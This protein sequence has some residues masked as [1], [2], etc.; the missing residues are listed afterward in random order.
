MC[1]YGIKH[2]C[3]CISVCV[4]CIAVGICLLVCVSV[5]VGVCVC[6]CVCVRSIHQLSPA[7]LSRLEADRRGGQYHS[8]IMQREREV[9]TQVGDRVSTPSESTPAFPLLTRERS[10]WKTEAKK[11]LD[12][13]DSVGL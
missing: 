11:N 5:C 9:Q 13:C 12:I 2:V 3:A 10:F 1:V 4:Y 6:E 8:S 7:V